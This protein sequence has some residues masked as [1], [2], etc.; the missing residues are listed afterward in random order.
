MVFQ[1]GVILLSTI[2]ASCK[3]ESVTGNDTLFTMISE[4]DRPVLALNFLE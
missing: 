3:N 1:I 4:L 2:E